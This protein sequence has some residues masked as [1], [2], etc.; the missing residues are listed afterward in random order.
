MYFEYFLNYCIKVP[1][2]FE[3][4]ANIFR[5][6]G[7]IISKCYNLIGKKFPLPAHSLYNSQS[8]QL[9]LFH[10]HYETPCSKQAW[11]ELCQAKLI[12]K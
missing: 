10:H 9:K 1:L 5:I 7:N 11:A 12:L 6:F 2:K 3:N 4:Y 8:M